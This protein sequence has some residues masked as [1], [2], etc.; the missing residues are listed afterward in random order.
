[1][2][3]INT[4]IEIGL[5]KNQAEVYVILVKYP[6]LSGGEI[7]KKLSIDRSF[8]YSILKRLVDQG[9]VGYI[10]KGRRRVFYGSVIFIILLK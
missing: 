4:L 9:L 10:T 1:M 7:A 3:I 6:E 2:N 8:A 5:T